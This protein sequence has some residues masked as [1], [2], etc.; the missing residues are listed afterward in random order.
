MAG[1]YE[2]PPL[3]PGGESQFPME[4][5]TPRMY[6]QGSPYPQTVV[7]IGCKPELETEDKI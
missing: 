5:R 6:L 3:P 7:G 2:Y 4:S 1:E